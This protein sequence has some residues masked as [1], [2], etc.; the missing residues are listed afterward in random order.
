MHFARNQLAAHHPASEARRRYNVLICARIAE[1]DWKQPNGQLV[2][3][4]GESLNQAKD[5]KAHAVPQGLRGYFVNALN[6]MV[7]QQKD[8]DGL[9]EHRDRRR[10]VQQNMTVG[11]VE[12]IHGDSETRR[13]II[14]STKAESYHLK[15][16]VQFLH[17]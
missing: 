4:T 10:Q 13:G 12:R 5:L 15:T 6:L 14:L 9:I 1:Y 11:I 7:N 17:K 3:Q 2:V 16:M 8:G